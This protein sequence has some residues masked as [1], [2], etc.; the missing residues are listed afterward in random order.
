MAVETTARVDGRLTLAAALVSLVLSPITAVWALVVGVPLALGGAVTA[1]RRAGRVALALGLGL[2][3]G[4]APYF[5]LA[6]VQT[7]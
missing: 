6:A 1:G 7:V 4:T 2:L 3:L 5:L